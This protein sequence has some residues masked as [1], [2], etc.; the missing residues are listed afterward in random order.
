MK[1]YMGCTRPVM[2]L[3]LGKYSTCQRLKMCI[4]GRDAMRRVM[5]VCRWFTLDREFFWRRLG[6]LHT[7]A[8]SP[9][10]LEGTIKFPRRLITR[11]T[12]IAVKGVAS[13]TC[14]NM[15]ALAALE[16]RLLHVSCL[17]VIESSLPCRCRART[18]RRCI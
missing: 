1:Y 12:G 3:D 7:T 8:I 2:P 17:V 4:P 18:R 11:A 15:S 6:R 14:R 10:S 13:D 9:K 5:I 16:P